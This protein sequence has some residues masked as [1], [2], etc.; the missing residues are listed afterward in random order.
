MAGKFSYSLKTLDSPR[1]S[2]FHRLVKRVQK[3]HFFFVEFF[4]K[5]LSFKVTIPCS[6][7]LRFKASWLL[8]IGMNSLRY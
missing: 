6:W 2:T 5:R 8:I 3:L 1:K 7:D 4:E